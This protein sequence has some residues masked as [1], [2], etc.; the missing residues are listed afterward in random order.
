MTDVQ[1]HLLGMVEVPDNASALSAEAVFV[2]NPDTEE[3][4]PV[5]PPQPQCATC[6]NGNAMFSGIADTQDNRNAVAFHIQRWARK[7]RCPEWRYQRWEKV[8]A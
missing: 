7:L 4:P 2:D 8:D 5:G 1:Q 3:D 6:I